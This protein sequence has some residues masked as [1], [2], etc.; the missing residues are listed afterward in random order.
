MVMSVYLTGLFVENV[1]GKMVRCFIVSF[2][3]FPGKK[4]ACNFLI[5]VLFFKHTFVF[6]FHYVSAL[7]MLP[8]L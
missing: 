7:S 4:I 2:G 8:Y 3:L 5:A 1:H 6:S